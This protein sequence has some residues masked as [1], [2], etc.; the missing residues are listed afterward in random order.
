METSR[1]RIRRDY[2][3]LNVAV[4]L[5]CTT[6]GSLPTQVYNSDN[7]QYEADRTLTPCVLSPVVVANANDGSWSEPHSNR[8][9]AEMKWFVNG[10]DITT[11]PD[12]ANEYVIDSTESSARGSISIKK[13]VTPG[14]V[15]SLRF[16]GVVAD[17]RTGVNIPIISDEIH[18]TTSDK[19]EDSYSL[20]IRESQIIRYNPFLDKLSLYDYKV[21]QGLIKANAETKK[22]ATDE[23]AYTC[24]VPLTVYKGQAP[25]SNGYTVKLYKIGA[26][27]KLTATGDADKE[28]VAVTAAEILIDLRLI[29]K[30]DFVIRIFVGEKQVAQEQFSVNRVYP[31]YR[32]NPTNGTG[33]GPNDTERYDVAQVNAD[34]QIIDCP[35]LVLRI[36]WKT[37]T[38]SKKGVTHNEGR[39]TLIKLSDTGIGNTYR[40]SWLDVY[41]ETDYKGNHNVATDDKGNV[42]VYENGN[43]LI[44]N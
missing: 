21:A 35:E 41:T 25:L 14:T 1:K 10:K 18:L 19:A 30:A 33:I 43:T 32:C 26:N 13:N 24:H 38:E 7:K 29:K 2:A 42:Y 36:V 16:E 5:A 4:S 8:L 9:L 44:F 31:K 15:Y 37:D 20:S 3:P 40:D 28:V 22:A 34:G 17:I 12:W 23:N 39:D 27:G 11:L 6:P